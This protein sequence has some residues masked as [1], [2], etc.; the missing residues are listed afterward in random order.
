MATTLS[1]EA[2]ESPAWARPAGYGLLGLLA[3]VMAMTMPVLFVLILL[4]LILVSMWVHS[5]RDGTTIITFA[6]LPLMLVPANF[7]IEALGA[8]GTPPTIIGLGAMWWWLQSKIVPN[9][10]LARSDQPIR[11]ALLALWLGLM[12]G[13][14]TAYTRPLSGFEQRS[15]DRH[16][17]LYLAMTGLCLLAADSITTRHRLDT[18]LRRIVGL[19]T[20]LSMVGI[21]QFLFSFD[22]STAL[23]P[24]GFVPLD[25]TFSGFGIERN[26]FTRV[27]ATAGHPI[28]F[29]AVVAFTIPLAL[30][31]AFYDTHRSTLARW[32]PLVILG[33]ALPMSVSRTGFL[34][35][36]VV[37]A[38]MLP[39]WDRQKQVRVGGAAIAGS[40]AITVI[41]PGLLGLIR[42]S[43]FLGSTDNSI[44]GRTN[45]YALVSRLI[46]ERP[47]FGRGFGTFIPV[48]YFVLD[49]Q[50]LLFILEIGI[51]GTLLFIA[52]V[53]TG[54]CLARGARRRA[55][56]PST[57]HLGQALTASIACNVATFITYDVM[58]FRIAATLLFI[59]IGASAALW[60]LV[61]EER[62]ELAAPRRR[63]FAR[64]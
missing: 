35:L 36:A 4:V 13:Y 15:T 42:D 6:L 9:S 55:V 44:T 53:I 32:G 8:A 54:I 63:R 38:V 31:F 41:V 37:A 46:D 26:Q 29:S 52:F 25:E 56:D 10:G 5:P 45:D 62:G 18:L 23:Q 43:F 40:L 19:T 16:I 57:R 28:E 58:S 27:A 60:R 17:L 61:R 24:P 49:N 1:V 33:F 11:W 34:A 3:L 22:I 47:L 59:S 50:W 12:T 39:T 14:A 20:V 30:H 51:F 64:L 2:T 21:F 48:D 7:V